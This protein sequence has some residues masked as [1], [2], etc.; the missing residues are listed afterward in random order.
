MCYDEEQINNRNNKQKGQQ[1]RSKMKNIKK[2]TVASILSVAAVAAFAGGNASAA[3]TYNGGNVDDSGK[4]SLT[5]KISNVSNPVSNVFNYTIVAD[6]ANPAAA[7]GYPTSGAITFNNTAPT[8]GVASASTVLD[9]SSTNYTTV[10]DYY[11]TIT[12]SSTSDAANYPKTS[13]TYS[14]I[15][16]VRY[17]VD[18]NNVPTGDL[19]ATVAAQIEKAGTKQDAEIETGSSR[20]H[21]EVS[22]EVKGNSA[23][24]NKCFKYAVNIPAKGTIALAGDTYTITSNSSCTGN[25]ANVVVGSD[26]N[27]INLKHGDTVTIGLDGTTNQMPLGVDYT[28]QL[29]DKFGYEDPVFDGTQQSSLST[30]SKSTVALTDSSFNS[31]TKTAASLEKNISPKTGVFVSVFPFVILA[32]IAGAGTI[33]VTSKAKKNAD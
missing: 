24:V 22:Q 11:Y 16:S 23:D 29:Q 8:S 5:R 32:A 31:A 10:G 28:I 20:T 7:T 14:A 1:E 19:V 4:L 25:S 30:P 6:S 12:E 17:A 13:E 21:I 2:I 3:T 18:A 26:S 27:Y 9:F 15:V 33:Y